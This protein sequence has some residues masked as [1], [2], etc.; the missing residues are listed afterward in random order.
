MQTNTTRNNII[1]VAFSFLL[2]I[3]IHLP[4]TLRFGYNCDEVLDLRGTSIARDVYL[5]CGRWGIVAWNSIV[6]DG[7]KPW[8]GG[9]TG[10]LIL[11][12]ALLFQ[13]KLL[14]PNEDQL[15]N[16]I[17][18]STLYLASCQFAYML[19]YS[20]M[21][22]GVAL[23]ILFAS[24]A[25]YIFYDHSIRKFYRHI[26]TILFLYFSLSCYQTS[27][28]VFFALACCKLMA[29]KN[30]TNYTKTFISL[31]IISATSLLMFSLTKHTIL[32]LHIPCDSAI[33]F[34]KEH[35]KATLAGGI[36]NPKTTFINSLIFRFTVGLQCNIYII[37][38]ACVAFCLMI[39]NIIF[40]RKW[41]LLYTLSIA[42]MGTLFAILL[43]SAHPRMYLFLPVLTSFFITYNIPAKTNTYMSKAGYGLLI[44]FCIY[45]SH[46]VAGMAL[47]ERTAHEKML[48]DKLSQHLEVRKFVNDNPQLTHSRIV[49]FE[50]GWNIKAPNFYNS[51]PFKNLHLSTQQDYENHK[52][53]IEAMPTWPSPG[54]I[55]E[56]KGEIII[57]GL[58]RSF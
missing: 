13:T 24:F 33:E 37:F 25:C 28:L 14:F 15:K 27:G 58:N 22:E 3:Y 8:S 55:R 11:C 20:M 54:S 41:L 38:C 56:H 52:D 39:Y 29:L 53:A 21:I 30:D 34:T 50:S 6:S 17:I 46:K 35:E 43:T 36:F 5:A 48:F 40:E 1:L 45:A 7:M 32:T 23:S 31:A 18:Y 49:I 12:L 51:Y 19:H 4:L 2:Y 10:G 47:D 42:V 9:I 26:F 57:K 44:I 16:R